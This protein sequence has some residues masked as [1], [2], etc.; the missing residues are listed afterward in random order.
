MESV[1]APIPSSPAAHL[2]GEA[3]A[4]L[5]A[6]DLVAFP[7][8]TVYGLGGDA[9]NETALRKIFELKGRPVE[10]PLILHL[11]SVEELPQ[12]VTEVPIAAQ[13]LAA[14][15]W[16][17]PL[18][19]VLPK[20]PSVSRILTGGQESIAVRVPAH[21]VARALL[22]AL[23]SGIAAP[24]A[25][26]YG[27]VSPTSAA[28]VRD[29]FGAAVLVLDGGDCEIGVESTIVSLLEATP[30]VLRPGGI[31]AV[32]L[33]DVLGQ[34]VIRAQASSPSA[35]TSSIPRVPGTT[36]QHYAP[37]TA[38]S[39]VARD[40]LAAEIARADA[41]GEPI[42]VLARYACPTE[43]RAASGASAVVL[44]WQQAPATAT[45]FAHELYARLRELDKL[46]ATRILIES[47]PDDPSWEAVR[48][49]LQR[50]A[51]TR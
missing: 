43:G 32:D 4:R 16:P 17:G 49:R 50:A 22:T 2:I 35:G 10:H 48:D 15:F 3:V 46:G 12:W 25:N 6:G 37:R 20:H 5:R 39:L 34:S 47:V 14:A 11:L 40:A 31:H 9:R 21:P 13:R 38:V 51:A 1:A 26:R 45:G 42:V 19:M 29:E 23:G 24:S 8:E 44:A 27:H 41:R 36:L 30:R 18:T 28:H 33:E 7:T